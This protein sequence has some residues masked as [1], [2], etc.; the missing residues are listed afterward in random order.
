MPSRDLGVPFLTFLGAVLLSLSGAPRG[1]AGSLR[2]AQAATGGDCVL[3]CEITAK[4]PA[5]IPEKDAPKTISFKF[6]PTW[7][8]DC[9]PVFATVTFTHPKNGGGAFDPE[10]V[11]KDQEIQKTLKL[12]GTT[13]VLVTL[14]SAKAA[15]S[16]LCSFTVVVGEP[17]PP[18]ECALGMELTKLPT[19]KA[20]DK[21]VEFK[22]VATW[23][24]D[25]GDVNVT[26]TWTVVRGGAH[27]AGGAFFRRLSKQFNGQEFPAFFHTKDLQAGDVVQGAV[28]ATS[29]DGG[30]QA[31]KSFAIT[32]GP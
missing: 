2:V 11:Q 18:A 19:L 22:I 5:E 28:T 24:G 3:K 21:K 1:S 32:V 7:T 25:C 27:T 13:T 17:P 6:K 12:H 20:G 4:P 9:D 31:T 26:L 15:Q 14:H 10:R 29:S 16:S 23:S 30:G 8:G